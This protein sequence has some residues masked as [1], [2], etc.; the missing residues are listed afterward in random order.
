MSRTEDDSNCRQ[1][2]DAAERRQ[3]RLAMLNTRYLHFVART[4]TVNEVIER[5]KENSISV[6]NTGEIKLDEFKFMV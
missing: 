1:E 2:Q 5:E 6:G 3:S 4:H